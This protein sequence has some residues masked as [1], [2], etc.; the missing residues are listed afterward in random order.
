[1][2]GITTLSI[3]TLCATTSVESAEFS[4]TTDGYILMQ[5]QIEYNDDEKFKQF[6]LDN[7]GK[8]VKR[9]LL[10]NSGGGSVKAALKISRYVVSGRFHT[11][12]INQCASACTFI[13]F[14]SKGVR[15]NIDDAKIGVHS[16]YQIH[17]EKYV[18]SEK[19]GLLWWDVYGV[20]RSGGMSDENA[21]N[22]LTLSYTIPPREM[23]YLDKNML[24]KDYGVVYINTDSIE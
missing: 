9:V 16:P 8:G 18:A 11:G 4:I 3:T 12:A 23:H 7:R 15:L 19:E 14:S 24:V 6:L 17:G 21:L 5:G 10:M 13:F 1:M 22:L 2:L 20:W